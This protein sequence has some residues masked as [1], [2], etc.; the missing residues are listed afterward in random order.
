[1]W[2]TQVCRRLAVLSANNMSVCAHRFVLLP[3]SPHSVAPKLRRSWEL[4][5]ITTIEEGRKWKQLRSAG[6]LT[7]KGRLVG[8]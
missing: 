5:V 4:E 7:G 6:E 8:Q 2:P 1:M 3:H